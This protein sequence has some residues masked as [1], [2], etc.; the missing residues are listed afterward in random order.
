GRG[1]DRAR[2]R[3]RRAALAGGAGRVLAGRRGHA[4]GGPAPRRAAG[5]P[6]CPVHLHA[7]A[8]EGDAGAGAGRDR[9]AGVHGAWAAGPGGAVHGWRAERGAAAPARVRGRVPPLRDAAFGLHGGDP[10][11]RRLA[12][13]ALRRG[14]KPGVTGVAVADGGLVAGTAAATMP[15]TV[16][17]RGETQRA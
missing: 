17:Q 5:G 6:G 13:A 11:P 12:R 3:A 7:G 8:G 10:R 14:L 1:A 9:A 4:V 2:G 16:P 15:A